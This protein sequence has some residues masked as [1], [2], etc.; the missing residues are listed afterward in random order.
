[1]HVA[2][3]VKYKPR[4]LAEI[5][6]NQEAI[7]TLERWLKSWEDGIPQQRAAFLHGPAGV[8]KTLTIEALVND[9]GMELVEKNASDYRTEEKIQRFAGSASQ[10]SGFFG[11]RRVILLDEMDGVHGTA[12][13]GAIPTIT[14][15]V[16]DSRC[17]IVL[18]A[19]DFWNK[20]FVSFRDK[21]KYLIIEFKKPRTSE[22]L[23][24]L[25]RIVAREGIV[26][27]E[28]ALKFIATRNQGD[29]RSAVNDLQALAQGKMKLTYDDVS[30]LAYR[31][32]KDVIFTVLR[33]VLYGKTCNAAK[34]A[35]NMA[36]VDLDMLFEWVYENTPY[37]FNVPGELADAMEALAKADLYRGRIRRTRNWKLMRYMID[38]MTAGVAMARDKSK[39][40][41]WIPFRFPQKIR[42]LSASRA[43]RAKKKGI[44]QKIK[45]RMH[46]SV[47]TAQNDVL[48]YVRIIFESSPQ[49]AAGLTKWFRFSE[50][51][52]DY[53]AG[54]KRRAKAIL[55]LS[56]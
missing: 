17:P 39:P 7:K 24:H 50:E 18:I 44:G 15:I 51:E 16:K 37:H 2:W 42:S 10:Y 53:I 54:G 32:R 49:M 38:F 45:R 41:G 47:V 11:R 25:R 13:R 55:K 23:S 31:D 30:W 22:L 4:S 48:P 1:M 33:Q 6:G 56:N 21:K 35:V 40:S 26:A 20:K 43:E 29:V 46:I 28:E 12:D 19:N 9:L 14:R 36:D 3:T 8:G 27:D 34:Q 52:V 5:V